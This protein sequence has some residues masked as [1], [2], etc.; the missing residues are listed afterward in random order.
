MGFLSCSLCDVVQEWILA[1]VT[2]VPVAMLSLYLIEGGV[3]LPSEVRYYCCSVVRSN[4]ISTGPR[5]M[6]LQPT[7]MDWL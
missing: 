5:M 6:G 4:V 1:P 2:I 3:A 7:T